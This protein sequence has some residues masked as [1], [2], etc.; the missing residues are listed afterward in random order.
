[1][2]GGVAK[3]GLDA[4]T[5]EQHQSPMARIGEDLAVGGGLALGSMTYRGLT[6]RSNRL[7]QQRA[8]DALRS[9]VSTGNYQA[10]V[11]PAT[12]ISDWVRQFIYSQ[13]AANRLPGQ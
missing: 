4:A 10:P 1:M 6:A 11:V 3:E 7:M 8:V 5:G 9:T 2:I 13:G 12:P